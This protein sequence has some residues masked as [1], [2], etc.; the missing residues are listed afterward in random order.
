MS[1]F[2]YAIL[3][4]RAHRP[5]SM[6]DRA[7]VMTQTWHDL[8][9]AHWR[10][11]VGTLRAIVPSVF[12]ID[13]FNGDAWLAV[14]PFHMSNVGPRFAPS[15]PWISAFPELNVRTYV[16]VDDKPGVY[17]FSLDASSA[18]AVATARALLHLPY[19]TAEMSVTVGRTIEYRSRRTSAPAT[20]F[21]ASYQP[22]EPP[23]APVPG[24]LE[25]F[26]TERYCLYAIDHLKHPYRL[27]IH[28][29]PWPL[30]RATADITVNTMTAPIDIA[31][32]GPPLLH[33]SGRQ[34]VVCWRPEVIRR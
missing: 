22:S 16:R 11:P 17:F 24:S 6:P 3:D 10:V 27:E 28:H 1:D 12:P 21:R 8:L 9:F 18:A 13:T 7:W 34:D 15:L 5:W 30:Q 23:A 31:L 14:V 19:F 4:K 29:P 26:L 2:N 20:E 33:F 25:W 32:E